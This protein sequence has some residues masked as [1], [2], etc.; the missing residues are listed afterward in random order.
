MYK[1]PIGNTCLVV[2]IEGPDRVG[3][4]TQ[5]RMLSDA[6]YG[7]GP[8]GDD[9][10]GP[11]TPWWSNEI[12]EVPHDDGPLYA[13]IYAMLKDGSAFEF[14]VAFQTLHAANRR[15]FQATQLPYRAQWNDVV[16]LDRW[17]LSTRVYGTCDGVPVETTDRIL[18]G[19]IE[20][21]ITFVFDAP[22]FPKEG[23][24]AYEANLEFQQ[25]VRS[26]YL[27]WCDRDPERYVKIKADRD[28][29]EVHADIF[30]KLRTVLGPPTSVGHQER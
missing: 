23:L 25:K 3:K 30:S 26:A 7:R 4:A 15:I 28:K 17:T 16:I 20:P 22:P 10:P 5:A 11:D 29:H 21:D 24:D 19:V 2:A 1:S 27:S 9:E 13:E 14:P 6:L 12:C 18:K 8:D